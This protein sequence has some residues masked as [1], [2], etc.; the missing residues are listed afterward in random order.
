MSKPLTKFDSNVGKGMDVGV[1]V[2]CQFESSG[3]FL[4]NFVQVHEKTIYYG[5]RTREIGTDAVIAEL[6]DQFTA[7]WIFKLR[8]GNPSCFNTAEHGCVPWTML[9]GSQAV[10]FSWRRLRVGRQ[11]INTMW[12]WC[13]HNV[14]TCYWYDLNVGRIRTV[15]NIK[16]LSVQSYFNSMKKKSAL[17]VLLLL[18]P[19]CST[20][21]QSKGVFIICALHVSFM[22]LL[23]SVNK[24]FIINIYVFV[25][26]FPSAF[27]S[28]QR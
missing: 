22:K 5:F 7:I 1:L 15:L 3:D 10:M 14:N 26:F 17:F 11:P 23:S 13:Q 27:Q 19:N 18:Q 16:S 12:D 24:L 9:A 20:R 6:S 8:A 25:R 28:R 4:R 21:F 2:L